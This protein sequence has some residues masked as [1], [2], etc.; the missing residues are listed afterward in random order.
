MIKYR[1]QR[2]WDIDCNYLGERELRTST[3][4]LD[5]DDGV[6]SSEDALSL[7]RDLV[8]SSINGCYCNEA[9]LDR[10]EVEDEQGILD[11]VKIAFYKDGKWSVD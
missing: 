1:L 10:V 8:Q 5:E 3:L 2:W 4:Y 9:Y 6:N 11:E 7:A